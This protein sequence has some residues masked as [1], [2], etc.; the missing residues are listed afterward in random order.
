MNARTFDPSKRTQG[1]LSYLDF[2]F[3]VYEN[4]GRHSLYE[5]SKWTPIVSRYGRKKSVIGDGWI[6]YL[7]NF[8]IF[9]VHR[10][11]NRNQ[12][13]AIEEYWS[14]LDPRRLKNVSNV[15]R[16]QKIRVTDEEDV[17][18]RNHPHRRL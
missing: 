4:A 2:G 10:W 1:L 7:R 12:T 14:G 15:R 9:D 13:Q 8:Y 18:D 11:H 6:R 3:R 17:G 16:K 5:N